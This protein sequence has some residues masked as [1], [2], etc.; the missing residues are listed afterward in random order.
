MEN[1]TKQSTKKERPE[2]SLNAIFFLLLSF[3]E[4]FVT[5]NYFWLHTYCMLHLPWPK[6]KNTNLV[7]IFAAFWLNL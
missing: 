6:S 7:Y 3:L 2:A 4:N 5:I 1:K